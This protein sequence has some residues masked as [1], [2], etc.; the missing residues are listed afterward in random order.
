MTGKNLHNDNLP[1]FSRSR[2]S[3]TH[4]VTQSSC[5]FFSKMKLQ[6]L[7]SV[8]ANCNF[9][10]KINIIYSLLVTCEYSLN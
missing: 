7:S 1:M 5:P 3:V 6:T 2:L 9:F 10:F 4:T 8:T